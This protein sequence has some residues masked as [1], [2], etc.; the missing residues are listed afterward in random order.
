M[1]PKITGLTIHFGADIKFADRE[2]LDTL[3]RWSN[4]PKYVKF[5]MMYVWPLV[6]RMTP[7]RVYKEQMMDNY[8]QD[9]R[10][11]YIM[12]CVAYRIKELQLSK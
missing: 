6:A 5:S 4:L 10:D 11:G 8:N 3:I 2:Q 12:S 1:T 7:L 9:N